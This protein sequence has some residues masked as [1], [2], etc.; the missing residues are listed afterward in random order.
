M[1]PDQYTN[2]EFFIE[3]GNGH[4]LYVYDWGNPK[5]LRETYSVIRTILLQLA[6]N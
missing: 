5:G 6:E 4:Q 3:V 1:T 2:K